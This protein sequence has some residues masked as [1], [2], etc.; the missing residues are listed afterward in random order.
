MK[1]FKWEQDKAKIHLENF[2]FFLVDK[3]LD[4]ETGSALPCVPRQYIMW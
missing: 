3:D 1:S 4:R 2:N